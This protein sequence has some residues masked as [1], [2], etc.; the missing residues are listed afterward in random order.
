MGEIKSTMDII[1]E[2]TK[3]LTMSEE[4]KEAL[5]KKETEGKVRGFLQRYI[6]GV[7]DLERLK[8]ELLGLDESGQAKARE[9][10]RQECL[11]RMELEADNA[12]LLQVLQEVLEFQTDRIQKS[13]SDYGDELRKKRR[14]REKELVKGLKK[15]G[16]SGSA[17]IPHVEADTEWKNYVLKAKEEFRARLRELA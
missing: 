11:G 2:K 14:K 12:R 15:R 1:M 10:L 4:E 17:V 3:G 5:Q 6:D 16:I 8:V 13:L 9:L 7:S